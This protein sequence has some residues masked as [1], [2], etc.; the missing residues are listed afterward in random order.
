MKKLFIGLLLCIPF[1]MQAK[2]K[3]SARG[4]QPS[5]CGARTDGKES[6]PHNQGKGF[7]TE[8]PLTAE[9]QSRRAQ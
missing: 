5:Q 2:K 4:H 7:L 1:C 6:L 9:L 8:T 3:K